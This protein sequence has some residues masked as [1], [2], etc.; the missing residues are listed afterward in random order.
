MTS[1][2]EPSPAQEPS[3]VVVLRGRVVT[4]GGV[5]DDGVVVLAGPTIAWVGP[6]GEVPGEWRGGAPEP[7]AGTTILPGLVDIHC[8]GGGGASFPDATTAEQ[9]RSAADEHLRHGT[10]SLVASLVTASGDVL[11][12]RAALLAD[13][14][15]AGVLVGIHAEGPFLSYE[16]RG[17]QSP[18]H[19]VDGDPRLV[20]RL[21]AAARGHLVTMTVAP[22][23]PGVVCPPDDVL[24]ALVAAGAIPSPGHS[25]GTFEQF[26]AAITRSVA[27]LRAAPG[28]PSTRPTATH[29]FNGMRPLH[30]REPGPVAASLDAAARGE[31]V[32]E[33]VADGTHLAYGTVRTVF[34]LVGPDAI[35]L[36][37]DA[38]AATGM[39]DGDYRL[40]PMAV[41]VADG[42]ARIV[43]PDEHGEPVAGAIAGGTAHLLDVVRHAVAAGVPL[44][45]AVLAAGR[46]PA[47]VLGRTD[48][49]VLV[50]GARAD[51]LVTDGALHPLRVLRAGRDTLPTHP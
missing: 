48:I 30:H 16:R 6:A 9:V 36:V 18:E 3:D 43:T 7:A 33:M 45:D 51:V 39:A 42:V 38:M 40:G 14:A 47:S 49:G 1:L 5:L 12:E 28:A 25:D 4:P 50:P 10:T 21:A 13:A 27:L 29:L 34:D 11:C 46:T 35:A 8:H 20:E 31:M 19:L 37:T 15:D 32:V 23:V 44:A 22:E 17:A 24:A 26:E 41:R 2:T